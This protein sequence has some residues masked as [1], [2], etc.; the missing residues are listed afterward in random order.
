MSSQ[1]SCEGGDPDSDGC[2]SG[3]DHSIRLIVYGASNVAHLAAF[4]PD[5]V[6][7]HCYPG[8][9]S[10]MLVNN[11]DGGLRNILQHHAGDDI[12]AGV[13]ISAGTNDVGSLIAEE[14]RRNIHM[15]VA[16][17]KNLPTVVLETPNSDRVN[18]WIHDDFPGTVLPFPKDAGSYEDDLHL[19]SQGSLLVAQAILDHFLC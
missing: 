3:S 4:L 13:V 14:T 8:F 7:C 2:A 11:P 15:L 6:E 12:I 19:S 10:E 18:H 16:M 9:S 17:C 1:H 5:S